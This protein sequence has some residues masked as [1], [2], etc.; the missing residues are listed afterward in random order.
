MSE[1]IYITQSNV[2]HGLSVVQYQALREMCQYANNLYN[3][4]LYNIRQYFFNQNMFLQYEDN[5]HVCKENENYSQLQAG[6]S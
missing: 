5:Y 3:V 6:V 1:P 4:A 2:I